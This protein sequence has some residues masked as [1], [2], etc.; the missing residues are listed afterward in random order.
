MSEFPISVL[1][2]L[3]GGVADFQTPGNIFPELRIV[4]CQNFDFRMVGDQNANV[5]KFELPV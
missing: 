1:F 3:S 5:A 4:Q 2:S